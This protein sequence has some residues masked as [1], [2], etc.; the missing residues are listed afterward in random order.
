M[1]NYTEIVLMEQLYIRDDSK[2]I[3]HIIPS[4]MKIVDF[5]RLAI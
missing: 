2:K 3:K 4:D 1:K 5:K